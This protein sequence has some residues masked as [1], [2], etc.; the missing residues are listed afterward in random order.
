MLLPGGSMSPSRDQKYE[1][2]IKLA[3]DIGRSSNASPVD[4]VPPDR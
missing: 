1:R 3:A 2:T 4:T